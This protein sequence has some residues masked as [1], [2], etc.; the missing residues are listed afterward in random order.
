MDLFSVGRMVE[1]SKPKKIKLTQEQIT[2]LYDF[3]RKYNLPKVTIIESSGSGI[4]TNHILKH[5]DRKQDITNYE[6]W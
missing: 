5:K 6:V 3:M 4:G 1:M 2:Q